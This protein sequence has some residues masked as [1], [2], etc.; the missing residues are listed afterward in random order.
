MKTVKYKSSPRDMLI[1][2]RERGRE[3]EREGKKHRSAAS[4]LCPDQGTNLQPRHVPWPGIEPWPFGLE[5]DTPTE[6][7][8][9]GLEYNL[10]LKGSLFIKQSHCA[11]FSMCKCGFSV[12]WLFTEKVTVVQASVP[13]FRMI[14]NWNLGNFKR[15]KV[16]KPEKAF[17]H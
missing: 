3:G 14:S 11:E 13:F 17:P 8:W 7:Q 4:C 15:E 16:L 5:E 2:L 10:F 6:P 9:P 12:Y 1:D